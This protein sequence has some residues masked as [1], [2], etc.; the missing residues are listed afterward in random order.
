MNQ[1]WLNQLAP[2]HAPAAPG[3][4]PPAPGWWLLAAVLILL[5]AACI[6]WRRSARRRL[7]KTVLRQ[8]EGLR[9]SDAD[10]PA[11]ARAIQNLLRRYALYVF[12]YE[13]VARLTG[14]KWLEFVALHSGTSLVGESGQSL[15]SAA[16]G[17]HDVDDRRQWLLAAERFISRA[18]R[19]RLTKAKVLSETSRR[20]GP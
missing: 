14:D 5:T 15:L 10:G 12:G 9:F 16:Y 8:L 4:W 18:G 1:N 20:P 6:V 2:A 3:W 11:V 7:R 19:K 17:H 13:T